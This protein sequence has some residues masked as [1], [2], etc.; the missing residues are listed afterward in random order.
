MSEFRTDPLFGTVCLVA[1]ERAARPHRL[2][3]QDQLVAEGPCPLC[4]GNESLCPPEVARVEQKFGTG[5]PSRWQTRAF[6][7]RYPAVSLE[8]ETQVANLAEIQNEQKPVPGFG[9][10]EVIVDSPNHALPFWALDPEQAVKLFTLLQT[11]VTDL[12]KD[13]RILC[14]QVFKNHRAG[15]GQSIEHPHLQLVGLPFLPAPLHTLVS[16]RECLV[17]ELLKQELG[18]NLPKSKSPNQASQAS[19]I[20]QN[21]Q[22]SGTT[23]SLGASSVSSSSAGSAVNERPPRLLAETSHFVALADYAPEFSYQFSIYPKKHRAGFEEATAQELEDL[24]EISSLVFG[25]FERLLGEFA[26]N[27]VLFTQPNPESFAKPPSLFPW[28]E[29]VHWFFRV[30]PRMARHAG[31]EFSTRIPIVGVAPEDAA[32]AFREKGV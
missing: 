4:P 8:A 15:G 24:A 26:L 30:Y 1:R 11:R 6:P 22:I 5:G 21:S 20:S 27:I 17:C 16:A 25:K 7:N 12:F 9:V 2:R 23:Q 3:L 32:R 18:E 31:F 19:Q 13:R 29:R 14:T 28:K 10:H